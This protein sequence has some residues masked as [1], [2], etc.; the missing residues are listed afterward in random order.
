MNKHEE[1]LRRLIALEVK[2]L[3]QN[4]G[5]IDASSQ[6]K[7]AYALFA[8]GEYNGQILSRL[9]D[10]FHMNYDQT[11]DMADFVHDRIIKC[12]NMQFRKGDSDHVQ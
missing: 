4:I 11:I 9:Q 8:L 2:S 5:N 12:I 1:A 6:D 3:F 7:I 10:M